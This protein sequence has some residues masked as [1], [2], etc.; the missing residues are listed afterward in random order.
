MFFEVM[1]L[2]AIDQC[3]ST[4]LFHRPLFTLDTFFLTPKPDKANTG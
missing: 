3:F 4:F 1:D 2:H